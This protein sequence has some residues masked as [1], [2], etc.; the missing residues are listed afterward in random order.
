MSPPIKKS[1]IV[2]I[3]RRIG[4]ADGR[5]AL[6]ARLAL[7]EAAERSLD[8]HYFI[9]NKD[10]TGKVLLQHLLRA[11]DHESRGKH[12]SAAITESSPNANYKLRFSKRM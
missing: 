10:M 3:N 8:V 6:A 5:K 12:F 11:A 7:A 9:W 4:N 1:Q 2:G